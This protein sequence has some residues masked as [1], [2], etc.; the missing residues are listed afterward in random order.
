MRTNKKAL[1]F[2]FCALIPLA[3]CGCGITSWFSGAPDDAVQTPETTE[4][5]GAADPA[6]K[7]AETE[8]VAEA[9]SEAAKPGEE[10]V[11]I[12]WKVSDRKITAY[13]IHY[14]SVES[15]LPH[16]IRIPVS[17]IETIEDPVSGKAHR[18]RIK[19]PEPGA[20]VFVAVQAENEFG[21]SA[22]SSPMRV[23]ATH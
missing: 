21:T 10:F 4:V 9:K 3:F 13:H 2:F 7:S 16:H 8:K 1:P 15:D 18:V 12:T 14:G 11:E 22:K 6:S 5:G 19:V 20:A 17:E 23:E